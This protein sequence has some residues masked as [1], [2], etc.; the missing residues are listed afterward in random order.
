MRLEIPV[1]LELVGESITDFV[2]V[3]ATEENTTVALDDIAPGDI[4]S[5]VLTR[6]IGRLSRLKSMTLWEGVVLNGDV[7]NAINS[8]CPSFND[9]TFFRC[10]RES[11]DPDIASFFG[12]LRSNSLESLTA[13]SAEG[14][15]PETLLA[16][17][18][19]ANSLK[20]LKVDGLRYALS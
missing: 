2:K 17:N 14:I 7:A 13:L 19:H 3:A 6:W 10:S 18:N 20:T 1:V 9:L 12:T 15:G 11:A 8:H 4:S 5:A 16:L